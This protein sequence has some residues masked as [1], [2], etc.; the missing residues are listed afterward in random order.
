MESN[1]QGKSDRFVKLI[2]PGPAKGKSK[3]GRRV[4]FHADDMGMNRAINKGVLEGFERGLLTSTS[5]IANAPDIEWALEH[6][7]KLEKSR[8]AGTLPS[9][10]LRK[11]L[12]D[13]D[14]P[15]DLGVH[16]NLSQGKPL[17][18]AAYPPDLLTKEG[19]FP[20]I[21]EVYTL[22]RHSLPA[23]LR[24]AVEAEL[25]AQIQV[26]YKL[27]IMPTHLNG[28]QYLEIMPGI[29]EIIP[30]LLE[31]Y[32]IPVVR[33][34]VERRLTRTTL[35]HGFQFQNWLIAQAKQVYAKDFKSFM[36]VLSV[37]YP[38]AFYGTSHA[39]KVDLRLIQLFLRDENRF[40][41]AEIGLHPAA[42][43]AHDD[44]VPA[45]SKGWED[46]L[47]A[48]RPNE[49]SMLQSPEL[50]EFL[51]KEKLQLGRLSD[52]VV[53]EKTVKEKKPGKSG[54]NVAPKV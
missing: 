37:K 36:D 7:V 21:M 2:A 19:Y 32:K 40:N 3:E 8:K 10:E 52:L 27:G 26:L 54:S 16:L 5:V 23:K 39:G 42:P 50:S 22:F 11:T 30:K 31:E 9:A 45:D 35:L 47:Q 4:V 34:A 44:P 43:S 15:F 13:R 18:G 1:A 12:G 24:T 33:V 49:L 28:H 20:G 51:I 46:P 38:D 41:L 17:T 53:A 14:Q 25:R 48:S 29:T 6:W